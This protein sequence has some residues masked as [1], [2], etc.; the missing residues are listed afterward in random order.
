M[1]A[2]IPELIGRIL[3]EDELLTLAD[4]CSRGKTIT[5]GNLKKLSYDDMLAIYRMANQ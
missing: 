2:S 4:H 5:I 1:P 3:T